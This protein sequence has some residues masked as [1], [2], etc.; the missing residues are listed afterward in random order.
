MTSE[1]ETGEAQFEYDRSVVGVDVDLGTFAVTPDQIKTYCEAMGE[2]NPQF[3]SGEIAPPG[4]LGSVSFGRGGLDPQVKFGNTTFMA[5]SRMDFLQPIRAGV[6]LQA[7]TRVKEVFG[8]TGRS[9]T[10]VFVV[11]RT[12]YT[13]ASDG[14]LVAAMEQS[15]VHRETAQ[16]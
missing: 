7:K 11:R 3:A 9:G 5:G 12:E 4:I 14:S 8:K 1:T 6:T 10:M 2:A 15:T 16:A 13:D